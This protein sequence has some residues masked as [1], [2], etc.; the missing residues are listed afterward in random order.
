M[1]HAWLP[2]AWLAV[3][4]AVP[5]TAAPPGF[6]LGS[7]LRD[8][9]FRHNVTRDAWGAGAIMLPPDT[10]RRLAYQRCVEDCNKESW[11]SSGDRDR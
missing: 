7:C 8:C 11:S 4:L 3:L 2:V 9:E 10:P 1:G 5:V 6:D